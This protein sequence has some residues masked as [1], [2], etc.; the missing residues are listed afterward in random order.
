M[1]DENITDKL[2][3]VV[4]E[5]IWGNIKEV[6]NYGFHFGKEENQIH[7]TIGLLLL[8]AVAYFVTR[9]VL[10]WIRRLFTRKMD[11]TDKLKFFS[12]FKFVQYVVYIIVFFAILSF[13]GVNVT[14]V[15]AASAALL[16]GVGLALQ[17]IFQDIIGGILIMIDKSLLV[18]DIIEV[19]GRVGRVFDIKLRTTRALTRDDKVIVIPNHKFIS[20][21]I[22]NFTQNHKTTREFVAVGVAYGSDTKKVKE[23]LLQS[24]AEDSR[25]LKVPKPF[26]SFENFGDSSLDF[27]INFFVS[28]SFIDPYIKSDIRFKID[29]LFRENDVTIPFPQRDIHIMSGNI[30]ATEK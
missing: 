25:I 28:D 20:D 2:S 7:I 4:K 23:L 16:V 22:L 3:D 13:A 12:F 26:V 15:L 9:F 10:K 19:E 21:S 11:E 14:P 5:D 18:G 17:E 6:L 29:A 24:V 8:V 30:S 27:R 1:Q